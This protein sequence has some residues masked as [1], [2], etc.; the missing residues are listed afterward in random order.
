METQKAEETKYE[1]QRTT[2]AGEAS[3]DGP[4]ESASETDTQ[5]GRV[6]LTI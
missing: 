2:L 1:H 3:G 6:N 4:M 5:G